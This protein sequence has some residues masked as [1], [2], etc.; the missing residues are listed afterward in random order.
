MFARF[1][2]AVGCGR[3]KDRCRRYRPLRLAV[4]ALEPRTMLAAA[5]VTVITHGFQ[6]GADQD[7]TLPTWVVEMAEHLAARSPT[8]GSIYFH[9]RDFSGGESW[10]ALPEGYTADGAGGT[11]VWNFV[12]SDDPDAEVV[13]VYDWVWDSAEFAGGW[14][15]AAA[16]NL[17]A[18]LLNAPGALNV[19]RDSFA[20]KPLHFI[21][22]SR[23][24]VLNAQT[25]RRLARP[26]PEL[27]V[28]HVTS[29]DPRPDAAFDDPAMRTYANVDWADNFWRTDGAF[30]DIDGIPVAGAWNLELDENL[31]EDGGYSGLFSG[32]EHAD[33]HLWYD[34]TI[35]PAASV[36]DGVNITAEEADGWWE[37]DVV[38]D[39]DST[40]A[41]FGRDNLGY[42][43]S[44]L[45][46]GARPE[47]ED[48]GART[49][50][51]D[52]P[53]PPSVF[54]GD[55]ELGGE[56]VPGWERHGGGGSGYLLTQDG[57]TFLR[58]EAGNLERSHNPLF[59]PADATKLAFDLAVVK[60][61]K[62]ASLVV[63]LEGPAGS[64]ELAAF[65]LKRPTDGFVRR[66]AALPD[67]LAGTVQVLSFEIQAAGKTPKINL[68]DV[69]IRMAAALERATARPAMADNQRTVTASP[70]DVQHWTSAGDQR[71][72]VLQ[73]AFAVYEQEMNHR[74]TQREFGAL[75]TPAAFV[76]TPWV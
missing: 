76:A 17:L 40:P 19:E 14:L 24:A 47:N 51:G 7:T 33:T 15:D 28:D 11:P 56:E 49:D 25:V 43:W 20:A 30:G 64:Q 74:P 66:S 69:A 60:P 54:N 13:L 18:S 3:M 42:A 62:N 1:F 71:L 4:E 12:N 50:P 8:V 39:A 36:I 9:D 65:S 58:L 32:G 34:A 2:R 27:V 23:G 61:R 45:A 37:S 44:R 73:L 63:T 29:L 67:G 5:G 31:L 52:L 22:H 57:E 75:V 53:L 72:N 59:V 68:D 6:F 38:E 46:A 35:D 10:S 70:G 26:F 55:F 41:A 21:G 16:D 48:D